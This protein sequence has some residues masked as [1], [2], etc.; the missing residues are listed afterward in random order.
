[1]AHI[2]QKNI[3]QILLLDCLYLEMGHVMLAEMLEVHHLDHM[4]TIETTEKNTVGITMMICKS[5]IGVRFL[6]L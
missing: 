5:G 4:I 3:G 2:L 1:M 6:L